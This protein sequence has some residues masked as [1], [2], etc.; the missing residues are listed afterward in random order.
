VVALDEDP[1]IRLVGNLVEGSDAPIN[2][3]D[4]STIEIGEP[5]RVVFAPVEDV[6]LPR[7]VR[8]P[9]RTSGGSVR[10]VTASQ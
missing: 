2:G 4:P 9:S 1:T 6:V 5:V 7:W 8:D 3:V 10:G